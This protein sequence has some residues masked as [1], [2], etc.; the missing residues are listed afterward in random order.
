MFGMNTPALPQPVG[1]GAASAPVL[2]D[3]APTA[4]WPLLGA[5]LVRDVRLAWR[6]PADTGSGLVFFVVVAS[7]FPLALGSEATLLAR[8]GPGVVWVAALLASLLSL[9]RLF[10]DEWADGGL[11]ALV[12]SPLPLEAVILS[13]VGAHWLTSGALVTLVSPVLA[14]QYGLDAPAAAL[15]AFTLLLG[16]PVL[17]LLGAIGAALTLGLRGAAVLASLVVLPLCVPVLVFGAGAVEAQAAGA[18]AHAHVYLL[19]AMALASLVGAPFAAA[20]A[21]RLAVESA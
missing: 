6:R 12:L 20:A 5:L 16:T 10:E 17:A 3:M 7:L 9:R 15:L 11:D 18:S 8:I 4:W 1:L 2:A 21:L 19:L 14:L 13:K